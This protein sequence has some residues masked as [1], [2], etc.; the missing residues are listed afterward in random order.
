MEEM[1]GDK[2][3]QESKVYNCV[4]EDAEG[5]TKMYRMVQWL[6]FTIECFFEERFK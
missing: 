4:D 1:F 3:H 2:T 6:L 5:F